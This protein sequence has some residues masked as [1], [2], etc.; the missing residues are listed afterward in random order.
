MNVASLLRNGGTSPT[1]KRDNRRQW[2]RFDPQTKEV[3]VVAD[4]HQET[5][6][7]VDESFGGICLL[8]DSTI[9][10]RLDDNIDLIY[11][12]APL[13]G[14][15]RRIEPLGDN[16]FYLGIE[17]LQANRATSVTK[18]APRQNQAVFFPI[19]GLRLACRLLGEPVNGMGRV[20]FPD[21]TQ[22]EVAVS[23]LTPTSKLRR[24]NEL[25]HA[26]ADLTMLLGIYRLGPKATRGAAIEAILNL[27]YA[28]SWE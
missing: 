18:D 20:G 5:A 9:D 26:D 21:G 2:T 11:Q 27:E 4:G 28:D 8:L 22:H 10:V 6:L 7:V 25:A 16:S 14:I 13:T 12:G 15:V 1:W 17:W 3:L 24:R 23:T 19:C